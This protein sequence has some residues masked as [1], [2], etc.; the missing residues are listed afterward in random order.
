M[1]GRDFPRGR[2]PTCVEH[3]EL[4]RVAMPQSYGVRGQYFFF[5]LCNLERFGVYFSKSLSIEIP[6]YITFHTKISINCSHVLAGGIQ[7]VLSLRELHAANIEE[8]LFLLLHPPPPLMAMG[9]H[10]HRVFNVALSMLSKVVHL[11]IHVLS[12]H[13]YSIVITILVVSLS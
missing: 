1:F 2:D 5:K 8:I 7:L 4:E 13:N 11:V 12:F 6:K 10:V 3:L 9:A